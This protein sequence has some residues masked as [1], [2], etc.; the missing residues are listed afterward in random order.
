MVL[1]LEKP[2]RAP[3]LLLGLGLMAAYRRKE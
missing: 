2:K 1:T 3:P